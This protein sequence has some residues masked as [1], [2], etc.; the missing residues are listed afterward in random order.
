MLNIRALLFQNFRKFSGTSGIKLAPITILTGPNNSGKSSVAGSLQLMKN[1]D[2]SKLPYRLKPDSEQG[3]SPLFDK[4]NQGTSI[5]YDLYNIILGENIRVLLSIGKNASS[6]SEI[7]ISSGDNLVFNFRIE[8]DK[9]LTRVGLHYLLQRLKSIKKLYQLYSEMECNFRNIRKS[10]SSLNESSDESGI[11]VFRVDGEMKR[12]KILEYLKER[13]ITTDQC[14]RLIYLFGNSV[15]FPGHEG[16]E[17][18]YTRKV[19]KIV[20]DYDH[21]DILFNNRFMK[22]IVSMPSEMINEPQL[23]AVIENEFPDLHSNISDSNSECVNNMISLLKLKGY[24]RIE[25][26]FTASNI[27]TSKRL[28][29]WDVQRELSRAI[30]NH[31]QDV[32]DESPFF[33][34][35]T[36]LSFTGKGF[37]KEYKTYPNLRMLAL[38]G[39]VVLEKILH[40][41][42][43]DLSKS[44]DFASVYD[45]SVNDNMDDMNELIK[46]CQGKKGKENFL[47]TWL[48]K[49]SIPDE[50][51][52]GKE[53]KGTNNIFSI[54]LNIAGSKLYDGL[55][56]YNDEKRNYPRTLVFQEPEANLFPAWQAQ[57]ADMFADAGKQLGLHFLIE[58][59]SAYLIRKFRY[60][61]AK[62]QIDKRD[63]IIYYFDYQADSKA[64]RLREISINEDGNFSQEFGAGFF[65]ESDSNLYNLRK[66]SKN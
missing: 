51:F 23:M 52:F 44:I 16:K 5:G 18:Q 12:K 65:D 39:G 53:G 27:S 31:L 15:C 1:L 22:R 10:V 54:L 66:F 59:H 50:I 9:I 37:M 2:M 40:D 6:V 14:E 45:R 33:R 41:M 19:R 58:T 4:K 7:H 32:F 46:K 13:E 36:A 21:E 62:G 30:E 34:A 63:I 47:E 64:P 24:R 25:D 61:V 38:F 3:F 20:A 42:E 55:R 56:D 17:E 57:L 48:S 35:V 29:G 28:M 49:F 26:E 11:G 60:L 43:S 8:D